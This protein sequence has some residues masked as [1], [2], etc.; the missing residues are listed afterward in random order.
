MQKYQAAGFSKSTLDS[1]QPL[2]NPHQ[3]E[4]TATGGFAAVVQA[5]T[6]SNMITSMGLNRPT[7]TPVLPQGDLV[8][9]LQALSKFPYELLQE[10][11]LEHLTLK[12]ICLLAMASVGRRSEL[13]A[14][15]FDPQYIQSKPK[16]T[17][18]TLF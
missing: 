15:V 3:T 11:S 18:V 1:W 12:T 13:Q 9:M 16:G 5:K 7:M 8:I 4:C 10:A 14:L 2:E 6:I 17:A